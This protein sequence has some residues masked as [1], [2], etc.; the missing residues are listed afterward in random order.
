MSQLESDIAHDVFIPYN[1]RELLMA[2]M[3]VDVKDRMTP[4]CHLYKK[5]CEHLWEEVL[6]EPINPNKGKWTV[7]W[8]E[9]RSERLSI[10]PI[11]RRLKNKVNRYLYRFNR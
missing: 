8:N 5:M 11:M 7:L 2:L 9:M 4:R 3:S 6:S 10:S 1:C